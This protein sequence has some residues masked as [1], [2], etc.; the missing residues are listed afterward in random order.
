MT[1]ARANNLAVARLFEEIAQSLEVA[2]E[3]GHRLRAYRRAARGV[4]ATSQPLEQLAAEGRLREIYGIGSSLEALIGEYLATGGMETHARMVGEH[5]PG[6]APLLEARGFGP[7]SVQALH[8]G[9]GVTNL[10]EIEQ[11]ALD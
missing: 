6:L 10:D 5:P 11:A 2:G 9:L 8:A 7:A 3:T 4:A 1:V